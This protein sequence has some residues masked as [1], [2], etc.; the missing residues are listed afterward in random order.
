MDLGLEVFPVVGGK[1]GVDQRR[2]VDDSKRAIPGGHVVCERRGQG[3]RAL[4]DVP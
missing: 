1:E 3:G 2:I 4:E